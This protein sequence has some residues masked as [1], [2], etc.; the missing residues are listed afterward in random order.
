MPPG[1]R[2]RLVGAA[3]LGLRETQAVALPAFV[4]SR[5]VSRPL[6]REMA[7]HMEEA[8][9]AAADGVMRHYDERTECAAGRLRD[10]LPE[11][12]WERVAVAI[13]EAGVAATARWQRLRRGLAPSAQGSADPDQGGT[14]LV[15]EPGAEDPEHPAGRVGGSSLWL[16]RRLTSI[17]DAGLAEGLASRLCTAER[18]S[19]ARR[20]RDI[21]D[22]ECN[23]EWLWAVDPNKGKTLSAD[24]YV[25]AVRLR[26]G[27]AG[28]D[29]PTQCANCGGLLGPSG[30]H[31][32]LCARGPSTRGHNAVRDDLHRLAVAADPSAEI[33]PTGLI[34]SR[35]ELRPADVLTSAASCRLA[36]L[37]VGIVSPDAEGAG[38]DCVC[39]MADRKVRRYAAHFREMDRAGVDYIPVVW[40]AYGRPHGRTTAILRTLARRVARR[41]GGDAGELLRR[42][43]AQVAT[44]IWRR[45]ARMVR[46]CWPAMGGDEADDAT[47]L[48]GAAA[49]ED[50]ATVGVDAAA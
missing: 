37:D 44:E 23:H 12:V 26:L 38:L 33:E 31:S 1:R 8:G 11:A 47:P 30:A 42:V 39:A 25:H 34:A 16:Q 36:A 10:D 15:L 35:P 20:L 49:G 14:R 48:Y 6:V 3:G 29:E 19:D 24:D 28:P 46:R 21:S 40:S 50:P 4:A 17:V 5:I 13:D 41:R 7:E 43:Q 32:L 2:P 22:P 18:W 9:L 45:A 27:A